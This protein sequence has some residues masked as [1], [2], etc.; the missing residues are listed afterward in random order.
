MLLTRLKKIIR[1]HL[2]L[3]MLGLKYVF[4]KSKKVDKENVE[5]REML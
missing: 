5:K 1:S 4:K 2:P 3:R